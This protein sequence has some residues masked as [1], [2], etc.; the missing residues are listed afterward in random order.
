[1]TNREEDIERKLEQRARRMVSASGFTRP[2]EE[3][4]VFKFEN[5]E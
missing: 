3:T 2:K 1:M 4:G 5:A